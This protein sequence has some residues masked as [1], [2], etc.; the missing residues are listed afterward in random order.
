MAREPFLEEIW[1]PRAAGREEDSASV[2]AAVELQCLTLPAPGVC[3][4]CSLLCLSVLAQDLAH[5]RGSRSIYGMNGCF[6]DSQFY[7][8]T[9][10]KKKMKVSS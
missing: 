6:Q 9:D 3:P 8:G 4:F 10:L 7:L 1:K 5:G 2:R